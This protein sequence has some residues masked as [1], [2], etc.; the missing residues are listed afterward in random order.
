MAMYSIRKEIVA[1]L[2][3]SVILIY[4]KIQLNLK[5]SGVTVL[6]HYNNCANVYD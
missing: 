2:I 6:Q 5:K 1:S 4:P 3:I